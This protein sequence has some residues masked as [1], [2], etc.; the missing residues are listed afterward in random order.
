VH[1]GLN[2]V[3]AYRRLSLYARVV[4]VNATVLVVA[5]MILSLTPAYV[6]FPS[7]VTDAG[8]IVLGVLVVTGANALLL[9]LTF[10]SLAGLMSA[11]RSTD[12]LRPGGRLQLAGGVEVEQVIA[13]FN[14]MLDE[15]ED[16][17][18]ESNRRGHLAREAERRRIGQELHDEIGQRLTGILLELQRT[19][20]HSPPETQAELSH[21]Q[22][23]TRGTLDEVGRIAWLMRP[24]ILDDLGISKAL[25]ALV[26]A[27]ADTAQAEVSL[28]V[29]EPLPAFGPD[30]EI[31]L[32]RV[33]QEG[34]TNALRHAH[35][36]HICLE[37]APHDGR[38]VKLE[39][40]DD[41]RGLDSD[42]REGAG[43]RGMR[44]RA[45]SIGAQLDIDSIR[46]AGVTIRLVATDPGAG[47]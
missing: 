4:I 8:V 14:Q 41:G 42:A 16:E 26:G 5:T 33:A 37:L 21:T 44:E 25:E 12:L 43:L 22:E 31:V 34:L 3:A 7:S 36:S 17:R 19:L 13:T 45:L 11:M 27:V 47:I 9:R 2:P 24:G 35:A 20:D 38:R 29:R 6:P 10:T 1:R 46:D 18:L 30:V 28:S 32:Y 23:L 15:L 40:A 39:I